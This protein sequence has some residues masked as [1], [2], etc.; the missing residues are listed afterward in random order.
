[1]RILTCDDHLGSFCDKLGGYSTTE[2]AASS[3]H[4][5][6][7]SFETAWHFVFWTG[8][9]ES[10]VGSRWNGMETDSR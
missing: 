3:G 7:L 9:K 10:N 5:G 2:A 4:N 8:E 6:D 1:M